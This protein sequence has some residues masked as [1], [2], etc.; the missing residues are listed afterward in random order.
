ML[1]RSNKF[2][3]ARSFSMQVENCFAPRCGDTQPEGWFGRRNNSYCCQPGR[4]DSG[5][6]FEWRCRLK[7][8]ADLPGALLRIYLCRRVRHHRAPLCCRFKPSDQRRINLQGHFCQSSTTVPEDDQ[9][10]R[11]QYPLAFRLQA[12]PGRYPVPAPVQHFS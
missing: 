6:C 9:C 2:T 4:P 3:R 1:W 12:F 8:S 5:R 11:R 7:N 10:P